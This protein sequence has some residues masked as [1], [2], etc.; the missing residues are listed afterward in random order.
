VHVERVADAVCG[1]PAPWARAQMAFTLAAHIILVAIVIL[2]SLGLLYVL[3]LS[4]GRREQPK[5]P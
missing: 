2:P 4:W 5:L 1:E 3:G